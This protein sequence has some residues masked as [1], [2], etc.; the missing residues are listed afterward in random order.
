ME[1]GEKGRRSF[2]AVTWPSKSRDGSKLLRRATTIV[3]ERISSTPLSKRKEVLH[4]QKARIH[5]RI[6]S[7]EAKILCF[8]GLCIGGSDGPTRD[9]VKASFLFSF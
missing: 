7:V 3:N 1:Y 2:H 9:Q 4:R 5:I 8:V 6:R